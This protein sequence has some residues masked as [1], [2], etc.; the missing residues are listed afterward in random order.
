MSLIQQAKAFL[1]ATFGLVLAAALGYAA[2]ALW[3]QY[4][5]DTPLSLMTIR[6]LFRAAGAV[7]LFAIGL[8]ILI[9]WGEKSAQLL[10]K[11][12]G[13]FPPVTT[14]LPRA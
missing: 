13:S 11:K 8:V 2:F 7:G 3:P 5:L 10:S 12:I 6:M 4:F 14:A 9:A 1:L